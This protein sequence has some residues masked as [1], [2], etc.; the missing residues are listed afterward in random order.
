LFNVKFEVERN[1]KG[2][3]VIR[4][5]GFKTRLSPGPVLAGWSV[6]NVSNPSK[7]HPG[8]NILFRTDLTEFEIEPM[9]QGDQLMYRYVD[10][11]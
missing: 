7:N 8:G 11:T 1:N 10:L 6:A 4:Q 2:K 9:G 3:Y 5:P